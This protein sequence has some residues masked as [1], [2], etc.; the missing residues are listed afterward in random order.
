MYPTAAMPGYA[1]SLS[2]NAAAT[3]AGAPTG[4]AGAPTATIPIATAT[5]YQA[6]AVAAA[7]QPQ[8]QEPRMQ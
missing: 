6:A 3:A 2:Q 1:L 8:M 5:T 7:G 4:A